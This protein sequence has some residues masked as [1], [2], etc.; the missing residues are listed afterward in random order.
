MLLCTVRDCHLSLAREERRLVCPRGHT[1]DVARSGYANLLQPQDRRSKKPG[2]TASAVAARRRLHDRGVTGP[3]RRAIGAIADASAGDRVLD[4]GCGDGYYL[5][6]LARETGCQGHGV[7]IS[8]PAVD[9]AARRF[10][11]CEWI[12]ANADRF[13]PYADGSFSIVLSITARMNAGEFRRVLR[14]DGHLL[15]AIPGPE[16]LIELRGAGR[17][18]ADRT[19][20]TFAPDFHLVERRKITTEADLDAASVEDVLVSIYRPMRSSPAAAMRL[21]FSLDLLRFRVSHK[22]GT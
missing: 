21:T 22:S 6:S 16:D 2:D 15:V 17:D 8:I 20:G 4:A 14:D 12:V 3:L 1:F 5:G 13:V 7:D 10:P 18:R 11:E 19:I 9:A